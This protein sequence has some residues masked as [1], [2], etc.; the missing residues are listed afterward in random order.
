[1][2]LVWAL[3]FWM[4]SQV[5]SAQLLAPSQELT[6]SNL[7]RWMRSGVEMATLA[8]AVEELFATDEAFSAFEKLTHN[9]QDR[10]IDAFLAE[11]GLSKQADHMIKALG[12]KSVGDY[13]RFSARLGNAIAAYFIRSDLG[14][15][16]REELNAL[17]GKVDPVI[18][19]VSEKDVA[20][21]QAHQQRL[22][23]YIHSYSAQ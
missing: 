13:M 11:K 3:C 12:W 17:D 14:N 9:E 5:A 10:Q 4:A 16:T 21:I 8:G 7:D 23:A 18:L 1:M 22:Q 15:P 19:A 20:F 2:R 6:E